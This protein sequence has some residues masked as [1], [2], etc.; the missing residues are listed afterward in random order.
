MKLWV[1]SVNTDGCH[2]DYSIT[3]DSDSGFNGD[4]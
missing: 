3:P 4:I 1:M 2:T